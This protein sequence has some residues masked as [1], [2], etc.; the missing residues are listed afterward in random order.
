MRGYDFSQLA[1]IEPLKSKTK[2]FQRSF[3]RNNAGLKTSGY[4]G[5]GG[6]A[7]AKRSYR[8]IDFRQDKMNI[9]GKVF[10]LEYDPNRTSRIARIHFADGEKRYILAPFDLKVGDSVITAEQTPLKPGNRMKLKNIPQGSIVHNVELKPGQGISVAA[11]TPYGPVDIFHSQLEENIA[12]D[13]YSFACYARM[14]A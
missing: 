14:S 13:C 6:S 5:R 1:K 3:G 7:K 2:G 12:A 8:D 10:A 11:D 4:R 9:P